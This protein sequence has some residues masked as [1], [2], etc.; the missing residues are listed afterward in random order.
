MRLAK[1]F[2]TPTDA[3]QYAVDVLGDLKVRT[4]KGCTHSGVPGNGL[5]PKYEAHRKAVAADLAT[6]V[7]GAGT[8][9]AADLKKVSAPTVAVTGRVIEA[10]RALPGDEQAILTGRLASEVAMARTIEEALA[11]RRMM[12][13]AKRVPEVAAS[14]TA[15][16]TINEGVKELEEEIDSFLYEQRVAKEIASNTPRAVIARLNELNA[17]SQEVI[18]QNRPAKT[19]MDT[20]GRFQ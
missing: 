19:H 6:L 18:R 8:P 16:E 13:A 17:Q 5:G 7:G 12:L 9:T 10:L 2:P 4:C 3:G 15:M 1:L 14:K 20:D 11:I